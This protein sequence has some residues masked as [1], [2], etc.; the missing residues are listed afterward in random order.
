MIPVLDTSSLL[1]R[2]SGKY[3]RY[4]S[5]FLLIFNRN[6]DSVLSERLDKPG[7]RVSL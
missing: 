1:E 2:A 7:G 3:F 6:R 4:L 5:L